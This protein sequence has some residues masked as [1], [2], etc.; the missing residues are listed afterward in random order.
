MA[1]ILLV[2]DDSSLAD[3]VKGWLSR[4]R[5]QCEHVT[6]GS[7]AVS[8]LKLYHYDLVILDWELPS[9]SGVEI[10]SQYRASGGMTPV[11]MLT[12]RSDIED[13]VSGFDLGAD[14][15]MTK[16]FHGRE[17]S[18]R[19]EAILRRP[20][21]LIQNSLVVGDYAFDRQNGSIKCSGRNVQLVPREAALVEFLMKYPGQF[22]SVDTLLNRI[23]P[24]DS[25]ATKLAIF[26]CVKR[27][28]QKLAVENAEHII[29]NERGRGYSFSPEAPAE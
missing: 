26:T 4:E 27:L 9:L 18:A 2:E 21:Q 8:M 16:P 11:L 25:E 12:G 20:S 23:W 19:V 10:L 7:D 24:N 22:F 1:K 28:R 17:L 13:K 15:Y 14:D 3:I 29:R 6:D 5:H